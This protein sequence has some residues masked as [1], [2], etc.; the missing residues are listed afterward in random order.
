MAAVRRRRGDHQARACQQTQ[1]TVRTQADAIA[2]HRAAAVLHRPGE[3][4]EK[5]RNPHELRRALRNE[6]L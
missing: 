4:G 2:D 3:N 5:R 6:E 1:G